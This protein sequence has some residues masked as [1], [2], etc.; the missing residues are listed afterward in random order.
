MNECLFCDIVRGE[1]PATILYEDEQVMAFRD[2]HPQAPQ[3]ILV[4]PR[5]HISIPS[6]ISG[7]DEKLVG[8]MLK[9]AA[10]ISRSEGFE[11]DGYRLVM[12]SREQAGQS[13][14]HIHLHI[15]AGRA[16]GW[17]PG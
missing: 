5:K 3:H 2:I 6:E 9:V 16:F 11:A 17:P 8:H 10:D 13:V 1:I 4:I 15:L 7:A 12:N 14:F